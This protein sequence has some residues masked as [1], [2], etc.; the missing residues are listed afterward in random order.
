[1]SDTS[2]SEGATPFAYSMG[3]KPIVC[4]LSALGYGIDSGGGGRGAI[5]QRHLRHPNLSLF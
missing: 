2:W 4:L 3:L 5:G 1:M